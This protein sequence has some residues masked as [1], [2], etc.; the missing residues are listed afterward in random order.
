MS[1]EGC[2]L[3]DNARRVVRSVCEPGSVS[4]AE[5]DID[6]DPALQARYGELVPVVIVDGVQIGY[7]RIEPERIRA[8]LR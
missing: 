7:W 4:W 1:R 3:C 2:H 8:A 6:G 5:V